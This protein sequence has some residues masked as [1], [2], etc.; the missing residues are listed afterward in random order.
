MKNLKYTVLCLLVC[1]GL[2]SCKK[3]GL[4]FFEDNNYLYVDLV[5]DAALPFPQRSYTFTFEAASVQEKL[6]QIPVKFAG[7]FSDQDRNFK[8]SVVESLSTAV[9]GVDYEIDPSGQ[10]I[11][12]G[13]STGFITVKLKR[14]AKMATATYD[15]VLKIEENEN[16]KVGNQPNVKLLVSDRII[17]PEWWLAS[18]NNLL[19]TFSETKFRLW[20][21]FM[22]ITDGSD[23][24]GIPAYQGFY[25]NGTVNVYFVNEV[26]AKTSVLAFKNWLRTVKGDPFDPA[27][28]TSVILSLGNF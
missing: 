24:W 20:L 7:R 11:L 28:N 1:I 26:P 16:F 10:K 18:H 6:L 21:E 17:K 12:A 2:S 15:L 14:S 25:F 3:D 22:K 27:L 5:K 9:N 13:K 23:P 4:M 8:V 19:G